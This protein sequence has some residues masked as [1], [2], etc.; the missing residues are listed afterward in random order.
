MWRSPSSPQI[1]QKYVYMQ[2]N[3]YRTPTEY[4]QKN[5]DFPKVKKLPTYLVRAKEKRKNRDKRIGTGRAPLG[6]SCKGGKVSTHQEAPS[7]AR[8]QVSGGSFRATEES[9]ATGVQTAKWRDSHREDR[10]Q[11]AL[12]S[13]KS[14]SAHPPARADG[15]WDLRLRLLWRSDP[16]ERTGDG[17]LNT[18]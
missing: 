4:W 7:L 6:G 2:S 10:C 3:S 13:P 18:A 14:L 5:S 1:H 11:P 15:C 12:T 16:R 8:R 9:T 17:C